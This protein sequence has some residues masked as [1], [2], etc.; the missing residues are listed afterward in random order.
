MNVG[1]TPGEVG[2]FRGFAM[3]SK[4]QYGIVCSERR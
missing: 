1:R 2:D 4:D 3:F